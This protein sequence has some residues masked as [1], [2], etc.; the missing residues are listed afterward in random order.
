MKKLLTAFLS[1]ALLFVAVPELK[2]DSCSTSCATNGASSTNCSSCTSIYIPRSVG[3]NLVRQAIYKNYEYGADDCFRGDFSAEYRYQQSRKSCDIATSLF[4]RSTLHFQGS[5]VKAGANNDV[6]S[7]LADNFGLSPAE[8]NYI[9]FA[10]KIKYNIVDFELYLGL[11]QLWEGLF[12]QLNLPLAHG[13]FDL[14][15]G[16]GSAPAA[17]AVAGTVNGTCN[18][19]CSSNN[20]C[21]S[22]CSTGNLPTP[23]TT[24]FNAG[25][26]NTFAAPGATALNQ[27]QIAALT[28]APA[29]AYCGANGALSGNFLF[30][31]MQTKWVAGSFCCNTDKT[32]LASVNMILGY[33]FYECADYNFGVFLRAAAPTGTEDNCCTVRNVF[34]TQIGDN[35]WKLGGGIT[36]HY[37]LYNCDDEHMVNVYFEGY[38]EHLFSRC[39]VRSFDWTG[40]GCLSRYMLLKEFNPASVPANQYFSA[41]AGNTNGSGLINGINYT[42]RRINTKIDVQGEGQIE[43]VYTNSCGFSGGLGWN[44]YGRSSEKGC[45]I[46]TPCDATIGSRAFGF[47]GCADVE[48]LCFAIGTANAVTTISN[49]LVLSATATASTQSNATITNACSANTTDLVSAVTPSATLATNTTVCLSTCSGLAATIVAGQTVAPV[50]GSTTTVTINAVVEPLLL[51]SGIAAAPNPTLVS[52]ALLNINSGLLDSYLSNK[53]FGHVDYEWTD[54]DWTPKVYVGGEVEFASHAKRGAMNAWGVYAG[55]GVS[56]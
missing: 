20:N 33:N 37:E 16:A 47:K 2:A 23:A 31:D 29:T 9:N 15:P 30:G 12:F 28:V 19:S 41:A 25:C 42:T 11:D 5:T 35:H 38:L 52:T 48:G 14:R 56:F 21:N 45:S 55:A 6:N 13:K 49:P 4:G 51:T 32:K 10:P 40:K 46:G 18:N 8:D 54:C 39:Q 50:A 7:L 36:G 3:D 24:P 53:V 44:I 26:M 1:V 22:T 34:S 27:A 43:F 17:A